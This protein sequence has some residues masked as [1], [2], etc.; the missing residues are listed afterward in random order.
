MMTLDTLNKLPQ[1]EAFAHLEKCC[2]ASTWIEQML[3]ERPYTSADDLIQ[4]AAAAW[5]QT[6]SEE[7]YL[8]A[9]SGHPKI[10]DVTSLKEKFKA[11][12]EW[13][14]K[15][16]SGVNEASSET[17]EALA[18]A[19]TDYEEKFGY[20]FIVSASGK[21][22][23]DMLA[24]INARILHIEADEMRVAMNEQH[25][26]TVIRLVKLIEGLSDSKFINS[27]ITT[28]ALDTT[29]GKPASGMLISLGQ[30]TDHGILPISVGITNTDGRISDL[31][32]PGCGLNSGHY[33]MTFNTEDYYN[34]NNQMGLYP[35]VT[36]QFKVT[37][38]KHYHIPLLIN[39]FGYS[40]YRGS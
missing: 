23:E 26:I 22:A 25:K 38:E 36:I 16:Q 6:C 24:I 32:A 4:K 18:K 15:E 13:A 7:D 19:N 14:G 11:S 39:P 33:C 12:K 10:G 5:F 40:T 2:V 37:D 17:I 35:E 31:L 8:D 9:F 29:Q 27:H 34:N 28:H 1:E 21:S 3:L 30:Q 20:I